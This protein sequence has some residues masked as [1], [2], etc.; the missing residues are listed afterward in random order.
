M[1]VWAYGVYDLRPSHHRA[2]GQT[3]AQPFGHDD[4]VWLD[5][6]RL[7]APEVA[8]GTPEGS[9]NLVGDETR[10]HARLESP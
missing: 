5:V 1:L 10:C 4:E 8:A 6:E 9:L 7:D 3:I 2:Y